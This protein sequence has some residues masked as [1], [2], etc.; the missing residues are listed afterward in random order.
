MARCLNFNDTRAEKF[1]RAIELSS[2]R[3]GSQRTPH[4][5]CGDVV[6][7]KDGRAIGSERNLSCS[8]VFAVNDVRTHCTRHMGG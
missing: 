5:I 7:G 4:H 2:A 8:Q 1:G 3:R 6:E